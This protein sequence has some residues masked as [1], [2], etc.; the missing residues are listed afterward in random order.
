VLAQVIAVVADEGHD[1]VLGQAQPG[2]LVKHHAELGVHE[3]H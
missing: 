3:A 1:R 2:Q